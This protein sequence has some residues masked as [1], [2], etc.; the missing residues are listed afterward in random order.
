MKTVAIVQARM[1]ST[2]LP[3]KVMMTA[4]GDPL[5]EH[6][7]MRLRRSKRAD[8]IVVA[9]TELEKDDPVASL[10]KRLGVNVWRGSED[11]VLARYHGAALNASADAII[12]V[13][14]DCPLIDPAI[15]D[16]VASKFLDSQSTIDY[17]SNTLE[18][19][20]PRGLD[21]EVFS[22][23]ALEEAH[24]KATDPMEREHVTPYIWRR[25]ERFRIAQVTQDRDLSGH[26]WTVDTPEDFELVRRL[27]EALV[28]VRLDF[29]LEDILAVLEDHPD[30]LRI[31]ADVPQKEVL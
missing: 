15:V 31:N 1:G 27:L 7:L 18:R 24:L 10:A 21:C 20:Y 28:P 2:R 13:T 8:D 22:F 11:D 3:G 4:A 29:N 9:T 19:T 12:R 25:P 5:L 26:R 17:A 30:W 16:L 14:G 23:A 6:L